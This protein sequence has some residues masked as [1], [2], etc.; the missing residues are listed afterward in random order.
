MVHAQVAIPT[1]IT[2]TTAVLCINH[3]CSGGTFQAPSPTPSMDYYPGVLTGN[4]DANV[5][6]DPNVHPGLI[7]VQI[8]VPSLGPDTESLVYIDGDVYSVTIVDAAGTLLLDVMRS[9]TYSPYGTPGCG[10]HRS[11]QLDF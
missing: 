1:G 6:A 7:D 8:Y 4:F 11:L 10:Q 5:I 2:G 9:V 3:A